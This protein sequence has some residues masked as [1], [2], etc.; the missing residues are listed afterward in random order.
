MLH[1]MCSLGRARCVSRYACLRR[2]HMVQATYN[3][4]PQCQ[5]N[6]EL[7]RRHSIKVQAQLHQTG[8]GRISIIH[9]SV[10][11]Q[12]MVA[13]VG[14]CL[15]ELQ[16]P[17]ATSRASGT[18]RKLV[19]LLQHSETAT[20]SGKTAGTSLWHLDCKPLA[21]ATIPLTLNSKPEC[22]ARLHSSISSSQ[23][24]L[25]HDTP[26]AVAIRIFPQGI[27]VQEVPPLSAFQ[28]FVQVRSNQD[29]V[30]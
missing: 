4:K 25:V 13:A 29:L 6:L 24:R 16:M 12:P 5:C 20:I 18:T 15:C 11:G 9:H 17:S 30:K 19:T 21:K 3:T 14:H 2:Q 26:E 28:A 8:S 27:I 10:A 22:L 23:D 7:T 1:A